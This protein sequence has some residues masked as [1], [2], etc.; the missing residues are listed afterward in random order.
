MRLM[1]FF[2]LLIHF[3]LF[4]ED[5]SYT[6][7]VCENEPES[8]VAGMVSAITGDLYAMEDDITIQGAEP[9][10]LRKSYISHRGNGAWGIFHHLTA[11]YL[12]L[13]GK[14]QVPESNGS[15]LTY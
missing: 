10:R 11:I 8:L 15:V 9:I 14:I 12:P 5:Y 2:L 3:A 6:I 13:A 7:A 1:L 4:S